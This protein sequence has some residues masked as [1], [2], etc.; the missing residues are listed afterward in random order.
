MG[1][2]GCGERG[3]HD[4]GRFETRKDVDVI[5]VCDIYGAKIDA[6]QQNAPRARAFTDHR[7]TRPVTT[8]GVQTKFCRARRP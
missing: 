6:A 1:L 4:M 7:W 3:S 2:I 8:A 5:A